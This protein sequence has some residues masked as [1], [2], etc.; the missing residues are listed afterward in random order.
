MVGRLN[1]SILLHGR[2]TVHS[3][4]RPG[5]GIHIYILVEVPQ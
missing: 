1:R 5:T 4:L 2:T 3:G